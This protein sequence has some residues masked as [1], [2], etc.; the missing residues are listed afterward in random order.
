MA[1]GTSSF[2]QVSLQAHANT[3]VDFASNA[4][5]HKSAKALHQQTITETISKL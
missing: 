5:T 3:A 2:S 4:G 1:S